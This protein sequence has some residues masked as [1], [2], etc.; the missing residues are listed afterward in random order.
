M[1]SVQ[2]RGGVPVCWPTFGPPPSDE[3]VWIVRVGHGQNDGTLTTR[4]WFVL[5]Y[6]GRPS[7]ITPSSHSTALL[8]SP[9]GRL[10]RSRME[11]RLPLSLVRP[12]SDPSDF[13]SCAP[14]SNKLTRESCLCTWPRSPRAKGCQRGLPLPF[15]SLVHRHLERVLPRPDLQ[16]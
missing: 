9:T 1:G 7:L 11:P 2:I 4:S 14:I 12:F 8:G 3:R 10:A 15:P 13:R 16:G 5:R 6:G